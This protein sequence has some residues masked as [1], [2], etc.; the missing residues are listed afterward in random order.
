[1]QFGERRLEAFCSQRREVHFEV[2]KLQ[3]VAGVANHRTKQ[4]Y[5]ILKVIV[6]GSIAHLCLFEN[7]IDRGIGKAMD[8]KLARGDI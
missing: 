7:T 2:R 1:M 5:L 8:R 6:R 3:G 4:I